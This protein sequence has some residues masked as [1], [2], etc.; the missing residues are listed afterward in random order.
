[1]VK[2]NILFWLT[3]LYVMNDLDRFWK[4][5]FKIIQQISKSIQKNMTPNYKRDKKYCNW[6]YTIQSTIYFWHSKSNRNW[7]PKIELDF[8]THNLV[9]SKGSKN[10]QLQK[11]L[12]NIILAHIFY[13]KNSIYW[14]T[15]I[16][17]MVDLDVFW[18]AN[19]KN[20]QQI[21]K[22]RC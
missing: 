20:Y 12:W 21:S 11:S 6:N 5:K 19:F 4:G 22:N 13:R 14:L 2:K 17:V 8:S 10:Y 16:Y 3:N 15:N 9:F 7:Q 18:K 1:M